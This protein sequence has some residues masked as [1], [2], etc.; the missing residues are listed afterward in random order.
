MA[1]HNRTEDD[2]HLLANRPLI[3]GRSLL[4]AA[5]GML[6]VP[7]LDDAL[8]LALRKGMIARLAQRRQV[9]VDEAALD[10]LC[11]ESGMR[12]NL[13]LLAAIGNAVAALRGRRWSRRLFFGWLLM[14]RVEEAVRVFHL[15]TLFD[16]YCA[17]HHLGPA[18]DA[19]RARALRRDIDEASRRTRREAVGRLFEGAVAGTAR[20]LLALPRR[21]YR[22][23]RPGDKPRLPTEEPIDRDELLT[24]AEPVVKRQVRRLLGSAALSRYAGLLAQGFDRRWARVQKWEVAEAD[25]RRKA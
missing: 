3:L 10:V 8:V 14:Q 20:A 18:L 22:A 9:D 16:H 6:P 13:G 25:G 5:A 11:N 24:Q 7:A 2:D 17:R 23:L 21:V 4:C 15:G 1:P 12:Q 19:D